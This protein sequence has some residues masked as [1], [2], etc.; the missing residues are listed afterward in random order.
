MAAFT[1]SAVIHLEDGLYVAECP[2]IGTV[3]Q[4]VTIEQALAN[5]KEATELFLEEHDGTRSA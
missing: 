2:E 5:L 4:A 1:L 3:S